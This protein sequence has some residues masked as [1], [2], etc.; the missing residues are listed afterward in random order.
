MLRCGRDADFRHGVEPL[1]A[2]SRGRP[3]GTTVVN[4]GYF[5]MPMH[6]P[7]KAYQQVLREDREAIILAD[8]L[9][10][11]EAYVGEHVTDLAE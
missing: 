9:G 4:L 7:G 2:A 10:Y 1:P 3:G 6:P 8:Q 11:T 5:T